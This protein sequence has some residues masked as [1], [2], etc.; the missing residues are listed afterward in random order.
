MKQLRPHFFMKKQKGVTL[1]E[2]MVTLAV[3][4]ILAGIAAPNISN[5]LN[6]FQV[7]GTSDS[8]AGAIRKAKMIAM[9]ERAVVNLTPLSPLTNSNWG[10]GWE[11]T[12][13]DRNGNNIAITGEF[14]N[15]IAVI[16][17]G[18]NTNIAFTPQGTVSPASEFKV[19]GRGFELYVT[20]RMLG[21]VIVR[22][23]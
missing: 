18:G 10:A 19:S 17:T 3:F 23:H 7:K 15:K 2:L 9:E 5:M 20:V 14:D 8:L 12:Y 1:L 13:I 22:G 11:M 16:E 21:K 6:D 4:G